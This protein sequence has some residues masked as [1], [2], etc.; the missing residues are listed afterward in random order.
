MINYNLGKSLIRKW[1]KKYW[2]IMGGGDGD[3]HKK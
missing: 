1:N 2:Y 3:M